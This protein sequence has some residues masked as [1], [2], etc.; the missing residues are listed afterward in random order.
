VDLRAVDIAGGGG[1]AEEQR[2]R[3]PLIDVLCCVV[4]GL[5]ILVSRQIYLLARPVS[6]YFSTVMNRC[7]NIPHNRVLR[8]VNFSAGIISMS[9][10]P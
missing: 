6:T 7:A 2:Q 5:I 10:N 4:C 3:Q 8:M 9:K 1:I